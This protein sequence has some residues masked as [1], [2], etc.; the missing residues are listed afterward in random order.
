MMELIDALNLSSATFEEFAIF[1]WLLNLASV[2]VVFV[3]TLIRA[4]TFDAKDNHA[5][6]MFHKTRRYYIEKY[7]V[8]WR[9]IL[10]SLTIFLPTYVAWLNMIYL[11]YMLKTPGS[12]GVIKGTMESDKWEIIQ[13]IQYEDMKKKE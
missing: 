5:V 8:S 13:I 7:T 9:R 1:G 12:W 11:Y 10:S 4:S 2:V 3:F 6:I